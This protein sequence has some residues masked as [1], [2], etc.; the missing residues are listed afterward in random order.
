MW[1]AKDP[2][3]T[4]GT[5]TIGSSGSGDARRSGDEAQ[6]S[7]A[8][9]AAGKST[10]KPNL[11]LSSA[12]Q[13]CWEKF[14]NFRFEVEARFVPISLEHKV[15]DGYELEKY[16]DENTIGVVCITSPTPAREPVK[17]VSAGPDPEGHRP[18]HPDPRRRCVGRV[19]RAVL[20]A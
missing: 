14:C 1:N 2:D 18:G 17:E 5:S 19:H 4:I 15:L 6:R 12:V 20:P 7:N 9:K 11:V 13:V 3:N 8:R 10:E 16:V